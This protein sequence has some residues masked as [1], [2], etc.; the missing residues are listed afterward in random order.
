MSERKVITLFASILITGLLSIAF[1]F[2]AGARVALQVDQW[3]LAV[4]GG[5][6]AMG[7]VFGAGVITSALIRTLRRKP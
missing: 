6:M 2:V 4:V 5:L 7:S 3:P 1:L